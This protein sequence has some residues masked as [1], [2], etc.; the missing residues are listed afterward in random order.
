MKNMVR[1]PSSE[2]LMGSSRHYA[3]EGP[4]HRVH[5]SSFWIDT[6]AVTNAE[7]AAF[8]AA[9]DYVTFVEKPARAE[10]YPGANPELLAPSSVVFAQPRH[11]V[12][13]RDPYQWWTYVRGACWRHPH[14]PDSTIDGLDDHP[15]VQVAYDDALAYATWAGKSLPTEAEWELAARGGLEGNE[16]TWGNELLPGGKYLANWWQGQFPYENTVADGFER[17]A[18][19]GSFPPNG[20]GLYDMAGN[21]WEW[22]SDWYRPHAHV[23]SACCTPADPRGGTREHSFDPRASIRIG[24]RVM[25]GGSY[26]CAPSY[27]HRYRPAARMAQP[28]DTAT[29]HLG[30]RCVTRDP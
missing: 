25:K 26:L 13:M 7:F 6:H 28:I 30:F 10:D 1:I 14:G 15:V 21:V 5:V 16:Y 29:C 8:V 20:F 18:P 27:C 2:F 9:T 4:P 23:Q 19:V 17:T 11:R 12:D 24:R 22:T 3:E